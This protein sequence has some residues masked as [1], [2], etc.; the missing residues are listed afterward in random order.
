MILQPLKRK[1]LINENL[2]VEHSSILFLQKIYDTYSILLAL[3]ILISSILGILKELF[4]LYQQKFKVYVQS[5]L[6]NGI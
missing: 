1:R 4:L 5:I 3:G 2:I 6:M